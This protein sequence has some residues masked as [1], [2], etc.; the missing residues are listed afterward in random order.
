MS[1]SLASGFGGGSDVELPIDISD[2]S[3]LQTELDDK[4]EAPVTYA[5]LE[6][7]TASRVAITDIA[8]VMGVSVVTAA[9]LAYSSGLSGSIQTQLNTLTTNVAGKA[10]TVHT[11]VA[12]DVTD[13]NT[14]T[15]T[16]SNKTMTASTN[17]L[18]GVTMTLGSDATGDIYYRHSDGTL[19]RLAISGTA[20]DFLGI[21]GGVPAWKAV[22]VT[23]TDVTDNVFNIVDNGDTSKKIAFQASGITASTTRT[24][25]MPDRSLTLDTIT[26]G[27]TVVASAGTG[28]IPFATTASGVLSGDAALN[29]DNTN[30]TI[31]IGTTAQ[32]AALAR[33]STSTHGIAL[34][35]TNTNASGTSVLEA[36]SNDNGTIIGKFTST[37]TNGNYTNSVVYAKQGGASSTS[38]ACYYAWNIAN[39]AL[40]TYLF[41][42]LRDSN[43]TSASTDWM[44][45]QHD[46]SGTAAA[47]FG[48]ALLF[49]LESSTTADQD[50]ARIK[51]A[52]DVA[53][54][55]S[56]TSVIEFHTVLSAGAIAKTHT[57]KPLEIDIVGDG[58]YRVN[59]SKVVGARKTGWTLPTGTLSRA[60]LND[61]SDLTAVRQGLMALIN[62]LHVSG[63]G[64]HGMIGA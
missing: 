10:A 35:I 42:G 11:H 53:T 8:G 59:G 13:L 54:H 37:A 46:T 18:G 44:L 20:T 41:A 64:K 62:D 5:D 49:Q 40:T 32:S 6:A 56:R 60:E 47:G 15:V 24:V 26:F 29:W 17:L 3:G 45:F 63:G 38:S 43:Q 21:T 9:E 55:A 36:D 48:G 23:V 34:S 39:Q 58:E 25:T 31:G 2:V 16:F 57:F 33:L 27:T 1:S 51:F 7:L 30:K 4:V 19:K 14:A 28:Y 50:A 12:A 61:S 22:S 52:W